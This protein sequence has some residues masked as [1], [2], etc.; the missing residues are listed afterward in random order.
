MK[1]P[2]R[3][4]H[5]S[6]GWCSDCNPCGNE[7]PA[8]AVSC[9]RI[10]G[11]SGNCMSESG[12]AWVMPN[13]DLNKPN[14]V[15]AEAK[16]DL[17]AAPPWSAYGPTEP[18]RVRCSHGRDVM[19]THKTGGCP[20]CNTRSARVRDLEEWRPILVKYLEQ[21]FKAEDWH[22]VQDAAS[23]LRDLDSELDGL[24]Y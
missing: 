23:D 9:S 12:H 1:C 16:E 21:K 11:H 7:H 24:R 15:I 22:G 5:L 17:S 13:G 10:N 14:V 4:V 6:G 19:E 3:W 20:D 18:V 8:K 2:G